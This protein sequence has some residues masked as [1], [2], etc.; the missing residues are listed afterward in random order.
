MPG[1]HTYIIAQI[2][3]HAAGQATLTRAYDYTD[4][5]TGRSSGQLGGTPDYHSTITYHGN[6]RLDESA[7]YTYKCSCE[8]Y[9]S[10]SKY[11][12][13][14]TQGNYMGY[15]YVTEYT[16]Q[17]KR[18]GKRAYQFTNFDRFNDINSQT[19]FPHEPASPRG[20]QRGLPLATQTWAS[21]D[22][23]QAQL[24]QEDSLGYEQLP[25]SLSRT[26][27]L[28]VG[29]RDRYAEAGNSMWPVGNWYS[30]EMIAD[31][32]TVSQYPLES[33]SYQVVAKTSTQYAGAQRLQ[34]RSTY[35]YSPALF[36]V[37]RIRTHTSGGDTKVQ[38]FLY[39]ADY[40]TSSPLVTA[41]QQA[42]RLTVPL[43]T[44]Q[45]LLPASSS[46]A[47]APRLTTGVVH[48]YA[49]LPQQSGTAPHFFLNRLY[50]ANT[51]Q[52]DTSQHFTG[53]SPPAFYEEKARVTQ[54]TAHGEPRTQVLNR[55]Q[56]VATL[57]DADERYTLAQCQN[58]R[59]DEVFHEDFEHQP[60]ASIAA[61]Y[62]GQYGLAGA[63]TVY[64]APPNT[65]PYWLRYRY[66]IGGR[67]LV[68]QQ[69]YTGPG[70]TLFG[71]DAYDDVSI[72][73]RDA[74]LTTYTYE[75]LVGQTSVTGPDGRTTFY[76]YDGLGR[77]IR[78]RDEQGRILS[79]QQ[80]HYVGK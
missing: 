23:Q 25:T 37:T 41:I 78:T 47:R 61:A 52:A 66:R 68:R 18:N 71:G 20:Y 32:L 57:W 35:T 60:A 54:T 45:L 2:N 72:Y 36:Q 70:T 13:F 9:T 46:A 19:A 21:E 22:N 63:Y 38:R 80:Y 11:P 30:P 50:A 74:Q 29:L 77:L 69:V 16:S 64:W 40:S 79:Q 27:G 65:R 39:P 7:S 5:E 73:P 62:S 12:L 8:E 15:S 75:P 26:Y 1:V 33:T 14:S 28:K 17:D 3:Q 24:V 43:E 4:P 76:E 49:L 67:W 31:M 58:A 34:Q 51:A 59:A 56:T 10:T 6:A 53:G 55:Y 44:T 48:Q 42:H